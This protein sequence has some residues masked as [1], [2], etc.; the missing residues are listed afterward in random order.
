MKALDLFAGIGL[1]SAGM[2]RAGIDSDG[3]A[4]D[5]ITEQL[6]WWQENGFMPWC[7]HEALYGRCPA[8]MTWHRLEKRMRRD[9]EPPGESEICRYTMSNS[10]RCVERKVL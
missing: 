3:Q 9:F 8:V 2:H 10:G 4:M 7:A 5:P 6:T 1:F